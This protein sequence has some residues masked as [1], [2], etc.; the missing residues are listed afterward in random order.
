MTDTFND[1]SSRAMG[2]EPQKKKRLKSH[3]SRV[4]MLREAIVVAIKPAG[5]V[6]PR[7]RL[8]GMARGGDAATHERSGRVMMV[9]PVANAPTPKPQL[10]ATGPYVAQLELSTDAVST[11]R[12]ESLFAVDCSCVPRSAGTTSYGGGVDLTARFAS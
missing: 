10:R 9:A 5:R 7:Q 4:R 8:Q 1:D 12:G 6:V 2:D 11:G 3:A